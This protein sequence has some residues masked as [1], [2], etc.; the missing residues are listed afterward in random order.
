M[1]DPFCLIISGPS[2]SGKSTTAKRLWNILDGNPAYLS[3]DSIKHFIHGAKSNDYFLDLARIN[4]LSLT[5][6]YL[7]VGHPVI[8]DKA[9]GCY[10][11]VKPFVDL[12]KE[13][14][15]ASYYFKLIAPLNVLIRRV[16]NR[17]D[18]SLEEKIKQGEWPL[19]IGDKETATKIYKFFEKNKHPEGIEIDTEINPLDKV[20]E[21][22]LSYLQK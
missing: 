2:G 6:N 7:K 14:G 19:P 5:R 21:I 22:I 18:F 8:L 12:T 15:V 20:I 1:S 10:E 4:A 9:F 3:L 13:I 16:E 17:K 11:Y